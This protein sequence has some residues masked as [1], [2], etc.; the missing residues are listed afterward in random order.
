MTTLRLSSGTG[1][2]FLG[3]TLL[4]LMIGYL[5]L[6]GWPGAAD[7]TAAPLRALRLGMLAA[8]ATAVGALAAYALRAA[9]VR[10]ADAMLGFGAGVML[11]ASAFSLVLPGIEAAGAL[12]ATP[13]AAALLVGAGVALGALAVHWL[14][15]A[16]PHEHFVKGVEGTPVGPRVRRIW[17]FVAAIAIHNIPEGMAIGV[18]TAGLDPADASALAIG[19]A[20]QDIP[21]GLVPV[22]ALAAVGYRLPAAVLVGVA[23][24]LLEP[25]AAGAAAA[26]VGLS[27][28]LLPI[29]LGMAGGA[30]LYVVSHEVIPESHR[31]DRGA[32]ATAGLMGGFILMMILDTALGR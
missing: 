12:G 7:Q 10:L 24:G 20:I 4:A 9:A 17:L 29:A 32:Q 19:I 1:P 14:D 5:W 21:E 30:M 6:A 23:S 16:L 22:V 3:V 27:G 2:L 28:A 11:A 25:L 15:R 8:A 18:A 26:I 13:I 31:H